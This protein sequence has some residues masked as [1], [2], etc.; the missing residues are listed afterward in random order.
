MMTS[1]RRRERADRSWSF[2]SALRKPRSFSRCGNSSGFVTPR[3]NRVTVWPSATRVLT[4]AGPRKNVPPRTNIRLGAWLAQA[5]VGSSAEHALATLKAAD[6]LR[7]CRRFMGGLPDGIDADTV[8]RLLDKMLN[9]ARMDMRGSRSLRGPRGQEC[10]HHTG[11][12][13]APAAGAAPGDGGLGSGFGGGLLLAFH[14]G[15]ALFE[16]GH[17]IDNRSE[18]FGL[19][20]L[21]YLAAFK[22]GLNELF[23][24]L[25]KIVVVLFRVP[26]AGKSFDELVRDLHLGVLEF[27]VGITEAFDFLDFLGVVHGVEHQA[28]FGGAQED[29]VLAVVHGELGDGDVFAFLEGLGEQRVRAPARF[30]GKHVIGGIEVDRVDLGF[31]DELEDLHGL[32]GL[33]LDLLD[34]FGLD[35]D[36]L[37]LAEFVALDDLTAVDDLVLERA[38][39]LLL[40]PLQVGTVEHV[41]GDALT[42]GALQAADRKRDQAKG[43][44]PGPN[45]GRHRFS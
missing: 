18:F 40:H 37:V 33:G 12:S 20:D 10:P 1:K 7:K 4:T 28:A 45:G 34:L 13:A 31:L 35:D 8:N 41:E 25:L 9:F 42:A 19:V 23:Q 15:E 17:Q 24:V 22:L 11:R 26:L 32:G 43:K 36:V 29:G 21:H 5:A 16:G 3:L 6:C 39:V 14:F 38:N 2:A 44:V 27:D 30:L